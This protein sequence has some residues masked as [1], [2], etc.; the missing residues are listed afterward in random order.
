MAAELI[1]RFSGKFQPDKYEDTYRE[2]LLKVIRAKHRGKEVH[3]ERPAREE[4]TPDLMSALR[5]SLESARGRRTAGGRNG[6]RGDGELGQLSKADLER[7]AKKAGLSG[8]SKLSKAELVRA[9]KTA[10]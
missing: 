5:A 2:A 4:E 9:L 8:Y 6:A 1:D 7:L 3:V 10:A